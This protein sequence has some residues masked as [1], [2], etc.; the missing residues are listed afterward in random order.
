MGRALTIDKR[1]LP[2]P[3]DGALTGGRLLAE[4]DDAHLAFAG[5]SALS[6][7][8]HTPHGPT[9]SPGVTTH[10]T[11]TVYQDLPCHHTIFHGREAPSW[12]GPS[13][14]PAGQPGS[15]RAPVAWIAQHKRNGAAGSGRRA[16]KRGGGAVNASSS[17]LLSL[18]TKPTGNT[19]AL[20]PVLCH[21]SLYIR[22]AYSNVRV[23][24]LNLAWNNMA[25]TYALCVGALLFYLSYIS[26]PPIYLPT[27]ATC[28]MNDRRFRPPYADDAA[29]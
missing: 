2:R 28:S 1:W 15:N 21:L 25:Q 9:C 23:H 12:A 4:K 19:I 18:N 26:I 14:G 29:Y 20:P 16:G 24:F 17:L 8:P 27:Y 3:A 7:P 6:P 13:R 22:R 5:N 10:D 11:T